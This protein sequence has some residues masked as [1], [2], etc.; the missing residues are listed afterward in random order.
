MLTSADFFK[1]LKQMLSRAKQ[2]VDRKSMRQPNEFAIEE[3]HVYFRAQDLYWFMREVGHD[4]LDVRHMFLNLR[5]EHP[6]EKFEYLEP[7]A[8]ELY[9][10]PISYLED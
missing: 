9:R 1:H 4:V 3:G 2:V 5:R 7:G 6:A 8:P 10:V